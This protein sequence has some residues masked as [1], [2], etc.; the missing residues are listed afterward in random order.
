VFGG[1]LGFFCFVLFCF[2]LFFLFFAE[3]KE[4]HG[5]RWKTSRALAA[6][7]KSKVYQS[8]DEGLFTTHSENS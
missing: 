2:F 1:T 4:T 8:L 6:P 3:V 5:H 7:F